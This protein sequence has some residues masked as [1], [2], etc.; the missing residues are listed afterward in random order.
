MSL[1]ASIL[2]AKK[3]IIPLV[4]L[5]FYGHY[6]GQPTLTGNLSWSKVLLPA[7]LAGATSAFGFRRRR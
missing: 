3:I 1:Y 5:S 7:C 6:T 2:T 4:L